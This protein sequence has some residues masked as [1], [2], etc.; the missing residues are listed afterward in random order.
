MSVGDCFE[1]DLT[2]SGSSI[3]RYFTVEE[4]FGFFLAFSITELWKIIEI[5]FLEERLIYFGAWEIEMK[6]H[7]DDVAAT[8][9]IHPWPVHLMTSKIGIT[10]MRMRMMFVDNIT[11]HRRI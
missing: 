8:L 7:L 11:R 9:H 3:S 5:Y 10:M 4:K 1:I 6:L 2:C